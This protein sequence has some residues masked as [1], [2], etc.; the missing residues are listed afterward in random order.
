MGVTRDAQRGL[1]PRARS[2]A[3]CPRVE[4][5]RRQLRRHARHA[6]VQVPILP[7]PSHR[8]FVGH[9]LRASVNRVLVAAAILYL[10]GCGGDEPLLSEE[11]IC[12]AVAR[13]YEGVVAGAFPTTV[14]ELRR[15]QPALVERRPF[16]GVPDGERA[17]VCYIDA[18]IAKAP[19]GGESYD[20]AVVAVVRGRGTMISAGY[21]QDLP[22]VRPE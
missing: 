8:H 1:R 9:A 16:E 5:A 7:E 4:A 19:P 14:A 13:E 18:S 20:R 11:V 22:V 10:A 12:G 17:V 15:L 21:Q 3:R 2:P 6:R